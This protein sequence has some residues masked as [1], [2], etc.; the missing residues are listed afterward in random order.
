M[1]KKL[2]KILLCANMLITGLAFNPIK[3]YANGRASNVS[4]GYITR[5]INNTDIGGNVTVKLRVAYINTGF[6]TELDYIEGNSIC[7][8]SSTNVSCSI[9]NDTS[10]GYSSVDSASS[11]IIDFDIHL[12]RLNGSEV[13]E[14]TATI[15]RNVLTSFGKR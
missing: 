10:S 13:L 5:T 9:V 3:I 1:F 14:Y 6:T 4:Y 11:M 2:I 7:T 8:A 15:T 12:T